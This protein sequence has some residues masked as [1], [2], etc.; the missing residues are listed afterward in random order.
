MIQLEPKEVA[1]LK[2]LNECDEGGGFAVAC[3]GDHLAA[4]HTTEKKGLTQWR[5]T[6][7]GSNFYSIT[8][9]GILALYNWEYP[10]ETL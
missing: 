7:Y 9:E 2:I 4:A 5:G 6:Q 10:N 3:H 1:L 8:P